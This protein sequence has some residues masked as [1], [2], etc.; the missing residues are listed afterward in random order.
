MKERTSTG[1]SGIH[2]GYLK[3]CALED[4]LVDFEA[5]IYHIPCATG[6]SLQEWRQGI[7]TIIEKKGKENQIKDLRTINLIEANF[8]Y[9]NK[10]IAKEVLRC[11]EANQLI[12]REQYG[13]RI[14]YRAITQ[15]LNK[16]LL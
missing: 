13:S 10:V 2:F 6:Y 8:N 14:E 4:E 12:P 11:D 15:V 9:S 3:A 1:I 5:V 16:R 7:N